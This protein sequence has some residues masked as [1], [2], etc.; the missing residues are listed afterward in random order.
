MQNDV[1]TKLNLF[2]NPKLQCAATSKE[3]P[4]DKF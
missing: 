1:D 4:T 2:K 3:S